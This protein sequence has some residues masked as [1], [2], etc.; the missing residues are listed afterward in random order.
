MPSE[1]C[2]SLQHVRSP[3]AAGWSPWSSGSGRKL[4]S[5][6]VPSAH[7]HLA[8]ILLVLSHT[9]LIFLAREEKKWVLSLIYCNQHSEQR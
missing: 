2:F 3:S 4:N 9:P 5:V 6:L 1:G 7:L 8:F